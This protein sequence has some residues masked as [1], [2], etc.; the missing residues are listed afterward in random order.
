MFKYK[1]Q[2]VSSIKDKSFKYKRQKVFKYKRQRFLNL[3]GKRIF[4]CLK[5][6]IY[7]KKGSKLVKRGFDSKKDL[8]CKVRQI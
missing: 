5:Q 4:K 7:K 1:R 2:K 3:K 8:A 6:A